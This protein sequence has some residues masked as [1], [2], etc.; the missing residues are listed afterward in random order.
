MKKMSEK[1]KG[2]VLVTILVLALLAYGVFVAIQYVPLR[3]E[4]GSVDS[5]L[6]SME[7][8]QKT[9][10]VKSTREVQD[11]IVNLLSVNQRLDLK[12][13]FKVRQNGNK[14]IISV[15]YDRELNLLY[16]KKVLKYQKSLTL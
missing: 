13:N 3:I 10:P 4:S 7:S 14:F 6:E 11:K 5:I 2:G 9:A 15:K 16:E 12:D 8:T 1:Q